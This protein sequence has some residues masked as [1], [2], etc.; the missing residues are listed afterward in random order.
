MA[1]AITPGLPAHGS[2]FQILSYLSRRSTTSG[3]TANR[4][5][6]L[7]EHLVRHLLSPEGS[8]QEREVRHHVPP[9]QNLGRE[10]PPRRPGEIKEPGIAP[11]AVLERLG[12]LGS[13]RRR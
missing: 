8:E 2:Y 4:R 3:E 13:A 9:A 12:A 6:S 1:A 10:L 11:P 7:V 5:P